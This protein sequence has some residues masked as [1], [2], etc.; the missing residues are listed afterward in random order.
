MS[1]DSE[2]N[3]DYW[4]NMGFSLTLEGK[5]EQAKKYYKKALELDPDN[6]AAL[7]NLGKGARQPGELEES[8]K[9]LFRAIEIDPNIVEAWINLG[10]VYGLEK[11]LEEE[12]SCYSKALELD[13]SRAETWH[14]RG[15]I[16]KEK[17]MY[18]FYCYIL[19]SKVV[20]I[21]KLEIS[22]FD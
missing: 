15:R 9:H 16:L 4:V 12:V 22:K 19:V 11:N 17:K 7:I 20:Y 5:D 8:K 6:I 13:P 14:N 18:N 2:K 3:P 1:N 21:K 10:V